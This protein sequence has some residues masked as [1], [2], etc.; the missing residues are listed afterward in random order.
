MRLSILWL[1]FFLCTASA[2]AQDDVSYT[3]ET[4]IGINLNTNGG[5]IGGVMFKR[6]NH[7]RKG[8]YH[9]F[10]FEIVNV[11]SPKEQ[12]YAANKTGNG[13][14]A[15]KTNYLFSFRPMYGREFLLFRKAE[16]E[17]VRVNGLIAVGPSFGLLKP[18]AIQYDAT[19]GATAN[20]TPQFVVNTPYDPV[21]HDPMLILG[22]G[23]LFTGI[24]RSKILPGLSAKSALNF[25]I[26]SASTG[27]EV[28]GL[29]E[30]YPKGKQVREIFYG[31]P[32]P[33]VFTSFYI[34]I[35]FSL[36]D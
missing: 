13:F 22:T 8:M 4:G 10:A 34:N 33:T 9:L 6:T 7:I 30:Y 25:E 1:S 11:K 14:I 26:G 18:Y 35:Y 32:L 19:P 36:R 20:S 3:R 27:I 12:K 2:F 24:N 15:F 21:V 23:G 16:E 29:I 17:G 5:L 28:G 31:T